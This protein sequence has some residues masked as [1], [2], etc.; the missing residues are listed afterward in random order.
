VRAGELTAEDIRD[1][2]RRVEQIIFDWLENRIGGPE[3]ALAEQ[4]V[5][6]VLASVRAA[7]KP[8]LGHSINAGPPE[9]L[10]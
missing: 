2:K 1:L 8:K 7:E 4:V 5:D 3:A 10:R 9:H 6:T